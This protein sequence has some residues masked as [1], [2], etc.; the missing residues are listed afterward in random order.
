MKYDPK[1]KWIKY[2]VGFLRKDMNILI[3]FGCGC[4][5]AAVEDNSFYIHR[6]TNYLFLLF[7]YE[8]KYRMARRCFGMIFYTNLR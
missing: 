6:S 8:H 4:S 1:R 7:L 5:R 2:V 3:I